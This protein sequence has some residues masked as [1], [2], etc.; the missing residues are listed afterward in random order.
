M[1]AICLHHDLDRIGKSFQLH[2]SFIRERRAELG[3][4][5]LQGIQRHLLV[6]HV[7]HK[8][9]KEK[10][11]SLQPHVSLDEAARRDTELDVT[12]GTLAYGQAFW[13][14]LVTST[15]ED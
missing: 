13:P 4:L 10:R 5:L 3:K 6:R 2:A 15:C 1:V 11:G 12:G 7:P 8:L 14:P 9:T